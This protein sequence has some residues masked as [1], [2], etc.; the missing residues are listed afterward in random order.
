MIVA[1]VAAQVALGGELEDEVWPLDTIVNR[2]AAINRPVPGEMRVGEFGPNFGQPG[3]AAGRIEQAHP[4]HDRVEQQ[5]LLRRAPIGH[6]G[7]F[8]RRDRAVFAGAGPHFTRAVGD[9]RGRARLVAEGIDESEAGLE[10]GSEGGDGGAAGR[11]RGGFDTE[12]RGG[13]DS[14]DRPRPSRSR[15][16]GDRRTAR[17]I[18]YRPTARRRRRASS[19]R[20][21][22]A[23]GPHS[24]LG[25]ARLRP[26]SRRRRWRI[27]QRSGPPLENGAWRRFG[28]HS[29]RQCGHRCA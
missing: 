19:C 16:G 17:P 1:A 10:V 22:T 5:L 11:V 28:R 13:R 25:P 29:G 9:H 3:P 18:A 8:E 27:R 24:A 20:D 26:R 21:S 7:A 14:C 15:R 4:E 2:A 23:S 12:E 6:L